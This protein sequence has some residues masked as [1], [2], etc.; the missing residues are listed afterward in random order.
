MKKMNLC[1]PT[2]WENELLKEL[3]KLNDSFK[4]HNRRVYEIYGSFQSTVTGSGRAA[5]TIP[6]VG[7]EEVKDHIELSH[8]YGIKFNYLLNSSCMGNIEFNRKGH[9]EILKFVEKLI[10]LGADTITIFNPFLIEL[11]KTQFPDLE[12]EASTIL[13]I[14]SVQEA[15]FYEQLGV[16]RIILGE[17]INRDFEMLKKIR[18]AV[19]CK[20]EILANTRCLFQCPYRMYHFN[21]SSVSTT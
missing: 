9:E 18:K 17:D 21:L 12:I 5:P 11:V 7:Y 2:T 3:N 6:K 1:V 14:D 10:N 16:D 13:N 8:S 19:N 20:L 15:L 4:D